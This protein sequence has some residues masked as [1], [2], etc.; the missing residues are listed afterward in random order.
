MRMP[1]AY[2]AGPYRALSEWQLEEHIREAES[3]AIEL[4]KM[5][6]SV[7]CPHKNTAHFGGILPDDKWIEGDLQWLPFADVVVLVE[8]WRK[9]RGTEIEMKEARRSNIPVAEWHTGEGQNRLYEILE[10]VNERII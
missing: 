8:G 10:K 5:G 7:L 4:W 2:V 9:S 1:R 6:F 3:V